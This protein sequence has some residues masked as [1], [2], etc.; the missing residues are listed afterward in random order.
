MRTT[1]VSFRKKVVMLLSSH[2]F[3]KG[4]SAPLSIERD[5]EPEFFKNASGITPFQFD[6]ASA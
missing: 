4:G 5:R 2:S 6:V 3:E 1:A